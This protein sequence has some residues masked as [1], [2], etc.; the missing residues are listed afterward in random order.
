MFYFGFVSLFFYFT[1]CRYFV[2]SS[3][4]IRQNIFLT[5]TNAP[6]NV[7]PQ[8]G[9]GRGLGICGVLDHQLHPHTGY[10]DEHFGLEVGDFEPNDSN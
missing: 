2:L 8:R 5:I 4:H 6:I 10:F 1:L 9:G 3:C 7:M